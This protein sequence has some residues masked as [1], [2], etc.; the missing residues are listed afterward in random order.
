MTTL[1][2]GQSTATLTTADITAGKG[3]TV[4]NRRQDQNG[5]TWVFVQ[6]SSSLT[7]YDAVRVKSDFKVAQLTLD[8]AKQAVEVAFAQVAFQIGEYGWVMTSG[9]PTVKLAAACEKQVALYAT[10]TG[11]VL[12]D[13]TDSG[14]CRYH[15]FDQL[16]CGCCVR[17]AVPVDPAVGKPDPDLRVIH[18]GGIFGCRPFSWWDMQLQTITKEYADL[19]RQLHKTGE[20][21]TGSWRHA[22]ELLAFRD[23]TNSDTV[24]D[25]GCGQG[26]LA[27]ALNN[28]EWLSE[29]DPAIDGKDGR[30]EPADLL[31]CT[32]VLE[33]IEPKLLDNVLDDISRCARRA[34]YLTIATRKAK[35]FL[36]D[37]RNAHLIIEDR[38]WWKTKLEKHFFVMWEGGDDGEYILKLAKVAQLGEITAKSAVADDLRLQQAIRNCGVIKERVG[39][40][41]RHDGRVAIVAYGPSLKHTY[42]YLRTERK[43]FGTKI[44]SV[45]GAHDFLIER[46]IVPDY[47]IEV[48]PREHKAW[49]TRNP[50]PDVTYWPASCCHPKLISWAQRSP[51]G[52]STTARWTRRS[53]TTPGLTRGRG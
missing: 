24:L 45:S 2:G 17:C 22:E 16:G 15:V 41:T 18:W 7:I 34:A 44:V 10:A 31:I 1:I 42:Q 49:F 5:N 36:A 33:H 23:E 43:T 35:K 39:D 4:G 48:D 14:R 30:P 32:D 29:Y 19:N 52:T 3:F 51:S 38:A 47:H 37:G 13:A 6:A 8:T 28:P 40:A 21:G 26:N 20:F 9:R 25:Y 12:D 53:L 50:H 11:G 27:K 46:G